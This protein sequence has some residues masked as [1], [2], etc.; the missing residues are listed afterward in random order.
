MIRTFVCE[1]EGC[2][3]NSFYIE[4]KDDKLLLTCK[5]CESI[6]DIDV[7]YYDYTILSQCSHCNND[8]FKV[9]RD[10]E[11]EGIY[12]KC[13]EC[14]NPPEIV[15]LDEEGTQINYESR[16]LNNIKDRIVS[17]DQKIFS[18][19]KKIDEVENGQELI[20]ESLAYVSKFLTE[21]S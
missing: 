4:S 1:K 12:L 16:V 2:S 7:S 8:T 15:Y 13:I 5:E 17:L 10:R 11:K 6:Y 21:I 20:E 19:E 14:G 3:G 18:L 9:F